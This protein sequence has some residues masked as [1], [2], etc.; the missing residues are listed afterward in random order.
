MSTC[1]LSLY[2]HISTTLI[3]TIAVEMKH[4]EKWHT[5][6]AREMTEPFLLKKNKTIF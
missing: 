3:C 4:T 5:I 2:K 1:R 6:V